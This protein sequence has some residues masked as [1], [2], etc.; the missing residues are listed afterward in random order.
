VS[1]VYLRSTGVKLWSL[2]D[3]NLSLTDKTATYSIL[4]AAGNTAGAYTTPFWTTRADPRYAHIYEI[5]NGAAS[6]YNAL[7]LQLRQRMW[8]GVTMQASYTWSHALDDAGPNNLIG[9]GIGNYFNNNQKNDK[10]SSPVDQRHRAT[11]NWTWRPQIGKGASPVARAVVNGWELSG[12]VTLASGLPFTPTVITS[13]LQFTG[14][15]PAYAGSLNGSGGWARV[16]FLDV[17]SL[18]AST[19][20]NVDA[21]LGRSFWFNERMKAT[22]LMEAFNVFNSRYDTGVNTLAY[23]ATAGVLRPVSG[24]GAGNSAAAYPDGTNA[25]RVQ[26]GIKLAF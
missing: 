26:I 6:W 11:F 24:L 2:N 7:A 20:R 16:P 21:R 15:T 18:R 25:R 10:G 5:G 22:L 13:G 8:R 12:M 14:L 1:A 19:V 4:D 9:V 17:N 23:V 3:L